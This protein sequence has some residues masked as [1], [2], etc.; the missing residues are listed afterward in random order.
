VAARAQVWRV[1][2]AGEGAS[3]ES[4]SCWRGRKSRGIVQRSFW[5]FSWVLLLEKRYAISVWLSCCCCSSFVARVCLL[6]LE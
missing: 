1:V 2:V 3:L 5:Y 4:S 6:V